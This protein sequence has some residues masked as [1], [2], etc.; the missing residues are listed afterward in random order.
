MHIYAQ[1]NQIQLSVQPLPLCHTEHKENKLKNMHLP[2]IPP[3]MSIFID[4]F[5]HYIHID[6]AERTSVSNNC[7]PFH[8]NSRSSWGSLHYSTIFI[9]CVDNAYIQCHAIRLEQFLRKFRLGQ[10]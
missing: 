1:C 5:L 8:T 3:K 9:Y 4:L 6:L 10:L 7:I 2:L